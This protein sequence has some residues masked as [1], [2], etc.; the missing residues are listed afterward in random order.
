MKKFIGILLVAI[1]LL[2]PS[3]AEDQKVSFDAQAAWSYIKALASDS[4]RGRKSGQ[5]GGVMG[6]EYIASKFKEWGLEPAGDN[7]TYFQN[8]TIEHRNIEEGVALEIITDR[9]RRDFYY[10]EGWRVQRYSGSGHFTAEIVFVGYGIHAPEKKYDD[11]AGVNIKGKVALI[12]SGAPQRLVRKL[13]DET[14]MDNR[15]EAA[16][17]L[18]ARGVIVFQRPSANPSRFFGIRVDKKLYKP[19]FV[20]LSVEQRVTNFI[21]KDLSVELR[22]LIR[23]IDGRGEPKPLAT[24]VKA[25]ISVNAIFDEKRSTRNVIAKIT[26]TDKVL[27]NEYIVIGAHMDH[28]G[29]TPM[30]DVMNGANDNA[31]GT[32]VTMELAR[33]MKLNQ[34]KPKRTVIFA[35]W[36]AEEQGLLGSR[37]YADHSSYPIEKTIVN[38]NMD[39]VGHGTGKIPFN[40]VYYGPQIWKVLKEK[41]PKEI[42]D[43][44]RTGRGGPGGSDHTPFLEKGIPAFFLITRPSVKYHQS[45]DDIDLIK[46]EM[47]KKTGDLVHAAV[48]IL[49]SEPGNFILP[50]R[51]ETYYL[52]Y[53]NIINFKFEPLDHVIANHGDAKDSHVNLQPAVVEEKE[54][55]LGN[56]LRIDI[57]N[58]L[59]ALPKRMRKAKGLLLFTSSRRLYGNARQGRTTVIL[60]LR[61]INSFRDNPQWAE[62]LAKQ[63]LYFVV[64]SEP[65]LLFGEEG[66][67]EEGKT[68]IKA[69]NSSGLLLLVKR[70][71]ELEAK[72]LLNASRRPLILF[73]KELPNKEI[74]DLI[75]KKES[76]LGLIWTNE[77]PVEY[78][79]KLEEVKKAIGTEHLIMVNGPCLWKSE[80]QNQFLKIISEIIKAKY[81]RSD[82]SNIFTSTFVRVL[83]K[84]RGTSSQ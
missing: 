27:K 77:E 78:F 76:A 56:E 7:G 38:I 55:L 83:N 81:E 66:L 59:F 6:E 30:G 17:K 4:M 24:G 14:K 64:L 13:G 44:A 46:P 47:L 51:Q 61:G 34:A 11:Y 62:I 29:V 31:S 2:A 9:E 53:Q 60:G 82:R 57:L 65:S 8:F 63:G 26:G 22:N 16:Q 28:L 48:E 5:P 25:F 75:K 42:L 36:A 69:I 52:K 67:S 40:G 79:N 73:E 50:M 3:Q 37:H 32:A 35:L 12:S 43:N 1:L 23:D 18:G 71:S 72:A 39:M 19:D 10:G 41:L 21:F 68:I 74:L 33:I 15:I 84:A 54:G 45:R 80:S 70:A 20:L 58:N 49:A